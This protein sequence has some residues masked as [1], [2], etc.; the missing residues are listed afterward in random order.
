M[1]YYN[2][3]FER[4]RRETMTPERIVSIAQRNGIFTVSLRWRDDWL[5]QRCHK[6][7]QKGLLRGGRR[8]DDVLVYRPV[9]L[10]AGLEG[11]GESP[12]GVGRSTTPVP[13]D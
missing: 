1:T 7:K 12:S 5:R 6:L 3:R 2:A 13:P 8:K 11:R 10:P 4:D 9:E